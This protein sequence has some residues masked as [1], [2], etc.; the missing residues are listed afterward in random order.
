MAQFLSDFRNLNKQLL[1]KPYPMPKFNE[2]LSKLEYFQYSI[3][4]NLNMGY[5]HI[6]LTEDASNLCPIIIPWGKYSYKCLTMGV[7]NSPYISQQKIHY[8]FQG[9]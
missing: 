9:Y 6:Q 8:L 5:Y 1:C 7:S 4:L 3:S 2:I